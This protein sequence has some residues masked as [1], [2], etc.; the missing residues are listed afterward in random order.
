MANTFVVNFCPSS[1]DL[2]T[3]DVDRDVFSGAGLPLQAPAKDKDAIETS[4]TTSE[5]D[6]IVMQTSMLRYKQFLFVAL[7]IFY[8][9]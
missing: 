2:V 7:E 1:H 4:P 8:P 5:S 9:N 3:A 6:N